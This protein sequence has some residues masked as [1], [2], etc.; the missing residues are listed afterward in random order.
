[1]RWVLGCQEEQTARRAGSGLRA[2]AHR[3]GARLAV[4]RGASRGRGGM[5]AQR[6]ADGYSTGRPARLPPGRQAWRCDSATGPMRSRRSAARR[7]IPGT[8][9]SRRDVLGPEPADRPRAQARRDDGHVGLGGSAA[10]GGSAV[11]RGLGRNDPG[12]L[13][14]TH[15][16]A[17][18]PRPPRHAPARAHAL[19]PGAT[20]GSSTRTGSSGRSRPAALAGSSSRR[21]C[22][23]RGVSATRSFFRGT[24]FRRGPQRPAARN[25]SS[26]RGALVPR[27]GFA[28]CSGVAGGSRPA[29]R[30]RSGVGHDW[31][32]FGVWLALTRHF[33]IR[34][35]RHR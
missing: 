12:W 14:G 6:H 30:C 35:A 3:A 18:A 32:R 26:A 7:P 8:P 29:S 21:D 4:C 25:D 15:R 1:M 24:K 10:R 23:L 28:A 27:D 16:L 34:R 9:S 2:W 11:N 19:A 22:A 5:A 20:T 31:Y 17:D 13:R 33:R